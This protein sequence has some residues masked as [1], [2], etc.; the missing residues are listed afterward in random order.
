MF[1]TFSSLYAFKGSHSG[2]LNFSH[3]DKIVHF[4]FYFIGGVLGLKYCS[5]IEDNINTNGNTLFKLVL[6]LILF[7][8]IIE[9][10]QETCTETRSGDI[11]DV[12]ANSLG[13]F[14]GV[15]MVNAL[16]VKQ[17]RLK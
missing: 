1:V 14:C 3:S 9:V 13:V 8:V 7:G 5:A 16:F 2:F 10:I 11:L 15:Y 17:R 12:L 4:M 6:S